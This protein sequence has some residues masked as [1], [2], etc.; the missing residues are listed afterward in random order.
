MEEVKAAVELLATVSAVV[1]DMLVRVEAVL[2][3]VEVDVVLEDVEVD[4]TR[5][6]DRR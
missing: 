5:D 4:G 1:E 6:R 3:D 2:A